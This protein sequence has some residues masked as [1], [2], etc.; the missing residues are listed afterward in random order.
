[1]RVSDFFFD[2]HYSILLLNEFFSANNIFLIKIITKKLNLT[3]INKYYLCEQ[4]R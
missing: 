3:I 1:M 2:W 4:F